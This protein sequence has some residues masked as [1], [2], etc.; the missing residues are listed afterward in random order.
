MIDDNEFK[1]RLEQRRDF[2]SSRIERIQKD[3]TSAHSSDWSEQ[4]QEREN[5]EVLDQL[6]NEAKQ[7]LHDINLALDR[8]K[9]GNYGICEKCLEE[10]PV[11]R[12]DI[13]PEALF[14]V[15][16]AQ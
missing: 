12:L 2:L 10:I 3:V 8:I 9:N 1:T 5:D 7:E 14:C 15:N 4:A 11:A 6:G 13:K 16:C